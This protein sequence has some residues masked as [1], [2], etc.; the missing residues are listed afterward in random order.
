MK[1]NGE[2]KRREGDEAERGEWGERERETN[3]HFARLGRAYSN[4]RANRKVIGVQCDSV[5][6]HD[7]F[8]QFSF[9]SG[10]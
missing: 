1:R 3:T 4:D 10:N 8:E 9:R 5:Y 6:A 7:C 2:G